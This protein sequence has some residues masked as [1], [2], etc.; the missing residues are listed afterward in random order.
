MLVLGDSPA[1]RDYIA[2]EFRS[3]APGEAEEWFTG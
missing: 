2:G 1:Q 3:I